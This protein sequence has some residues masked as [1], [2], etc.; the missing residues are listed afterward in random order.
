MKKA[1]AVFIVL[2]LFGTAGIANA[3]D[4]ATGTVDGTVMDA[5]G[6]GLPG[7]Q[8]TLSGEYARGQNIVFTGPSGQ[9]RMTLLLPG[10]YTLTF[11]L[12]GFAIIDRQEVEIGVQRTTS[13]DINM[14]LSAI[15]ETITV[16]GRSPM[17]DIKSTK[18]S[19]EYSDAL[20]NVLP[21]SRG[22]GGDLM[23]L[24][25]EATPSGNSSSASGA[26]FFG[27]NST[28]YMVDGVNVSDPAG[29]SQFP[30]YS[31]DWFEVVE[32][33][34]L[35]GGAEYGKYQGVAFNVVT[36]SGGNTYHGEANY[37]FQNAKFISD[38][39]AAVNQEYPDDPFSPPVLDYRHDFTF[40]A[41]GP[42]V[43]DKMWFFASYQAFYDDNTPAGISY[44]VSQNSDRFFGKFTWQVN[45]DNRFVGSMMND[46]YTLNGRPASR[47][48]N[49]EQ[50]GWEPSMNV[51]PNITWNSVLNP[52]MFLEVKYSG[53]YGY[54]DL[55]AFTD[56]PT[57]WD[58]GYWFYFGGYAGHYADDRSRTNIQG[59]LNY[60]VEDWGGDHS[61]KFGAEWERNGQTTSYQYNANLD[62]IEVMGQ[63]YA[64]G[65]LGL[66]YY[67]YYGSPYMAY[68]YD[69]NNQ[70]S[71]QTS[72][73]SPLTV[74][75]QDDWTVGDRVTLNL[76]IRFDHWT[77]GYKGGRSVPNTPVFNDLSPR[78]GVNFDV[79]GDGTTSIN[80]FYG[81]Y[82][83]EAHGYAF[84]DF[85]PIRSTRYRL[86]WDGAGYNDIYDRNDPLQDI[87]FDPG[88]TNQYS[89]QYVIGVDRQVTEDFAVTVRYIYKK[90]ENIYAGQDIRTQ[91]M[92]VQAETGFGDTITL[93]NA[94][95]GLNRFRYMTNNPW[96]SL[97]GD[98]YREYS[99]LQLKATKRL[100]DNWSLIASLLIQKST[101]NNTASTGS[102]ST[103]DDPND[104]SGYPGWLSASRTYV[105]KIQASYRIPVPVV[106]IQVGAI[107]NWMSGGRETPM[108][109]LRYFQVNGQDVRFGQSSVTAA[110]EQRGSWIKESMFK[111]DLRLDA[112]FPLGGAWG[113]VGLVFDIFNVFNDDTITNVYDR[114]DSGEL[115]LPSGIAQ[116]R[117]MRLGVRWIF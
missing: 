72:V 28:A 65:T 42:L 91:F 49:Q 58:G 31:P 59:S 32:L 9:F 7:V 6:V 103:R 5:D 117:I 83:E 40:G 54:Y 85:D 1:C 88:L 71:I 12:Q 38:N 78:L 68:L 66:Y 96:S 60:Y 113:D 87:G 46:T 112:K 89:K 27:E 92:P 53:F 84:N 73:Q 102:L 114:V 70:Q 55:I 18:R 11:Q 80:A 57:I 2:V 10:T 69:P 51:T 100:A 116:P 110:I 109:R 37:F 30:F 56:E 23:N 19:S 17:V 36:K 3:Q 62:T 75:L 39:T 20:R 79:F 25:P 108:E 8:V 47:L 105:S 34:S 21:E 81:K 95:N 45:Q 15:E 106:P 77:I 98:S 99:G 67:N 22:V 16:T 115:G 24:A 63:E 4:K 35:G 86:F 13:I 111:L 74:Y 26:N 52:N 14:Q 93:Y 104:F 50:S 94:P 43:R 44:P 107:V 29:G 61:F 101:G 76:G 90:A 41:G 48:R 33:T 97:F 82:Y 64:P